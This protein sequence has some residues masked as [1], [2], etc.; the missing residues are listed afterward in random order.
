MTGQIAILGGTG[1]LGFGMALR[2]ARA[3]F[4][5]VIGSRDADRARGA[6]ER[7]ERVLPGASFLGAENA[8]AAAAAEQLVIV[9]VPFSSQVST[10]KSIVP[11]LRPGHIVVDATVPLAPAVGGRPTQLLGVWQ[12]SA[13]Q[14]ARSVVPDGI[15][16]VSALHTLSAAVL[17]DLD[18]DL[19]QDT[20]VCGDSSA[21]KA[22]VTDVL[23]RIEGLRAVDAGRLEASRLVEGLT[24][25]LIGINM[26]N[27][28]H[29]GIRIV[30]LD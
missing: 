28:T 26:R 30:G 14:Q 27:K 9:A 19:A 29:T 25:L 7:A 6:A 21:D 15:G 8:E 10:L 1:N 4:P 23:S 3:G 24:P 5:V 22:S 13:A 11:S 20:F 18:A 2:L 12:G 16:V 17:E